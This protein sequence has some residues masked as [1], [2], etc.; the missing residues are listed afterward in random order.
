MIRRHKLPFPDCLVTFSSRDHRKNIKRT[1][2]ALEAARKQIPRQTGLVILGCL[3][4]E[5]SICSSHV[6]TP[7]PV[8][9]I[10]PWLT[11]SKG[12]IYTSLYEGFGQ[13]NL[14]GFSARIPVITSNCSSMPAVARDALSR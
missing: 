2:E 5:F 11:C 10:I 8:D 14:E 1:A 3:P 4:P 7:G 6:F 13:P 9:D 12:L